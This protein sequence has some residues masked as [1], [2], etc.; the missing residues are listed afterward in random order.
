MGR[1]DPATT[2]APFPSS[3][4]PRCPAGDDHVCALRTGSVVCWGSNGSGELGNGTYNDASLPAVVTGLTD[5][6]QVASGAYHT[7]AVRSDATAVCWGGNDWGQLGNGTTAYS[8]VPVAV[9]GLTNVASISAGTAYSCALKKDASV[10]CWGRNDSGQLG[11]GSNPKQLTPQ[12]VAGLT[13]VSAISAGDNHACVIASAGA[14]Y[15]WGSNSDGQLGNSTVMESNA[16]MQV[17]G[18]TGATAIASG[19]QYSCAIVGSGVRCWGSN[20]AGRLGNSSTNDS[21]T[22]VSAFAL[23]GAATIAAGTHSCA[24]TTSGAVMCWGT[25]GWGNL[26]IGDPTI[27]SV[28][29]PPSV[30][31]LSDVAAV[32]VGGDYA[33]ALTH[34][35]HISCWGNNS[36][37]RTGRNTR[38]MATSPIPVV[39]VSNATEVVSGADH[40]C[41]AL[42]DGGITCWGDNTFGQLAVDPSL[43]ASGTPLPAVVPTLSGLAM[44]GSHSCGVAAGDAGVVCWGCDVNGQLGNGTWQTWSP[45]NMPSSFPVPG[46]ATSVVAGSDHT[47]AVVA[48]GGIYCAGDG[49]WGEIGNG[50]TAG[51][52]VP[53]LATTGVLAAEASHYDTCVTGSAGSHGVLGRERRRSSRDL[54]RRPIPPVTPAPF[55]MLDGGTPVAIAQGYEHACALLSGESVSCWGQ[56]GAGQLGN[57]TGADSPTPVAVVLSGA[58]KQ[59]VAG[60]YHS[61]A[62]LSSGTVACWG[63]GAKGQLGNGLGVN[64]LTPVGVMGLRQRRRADG[65]RRR[66][67]NARLKDSG[68]AVCWGSNPDGQLGDGTP[69]LFY[70]PGAVTGF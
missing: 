8:S 5:A 24:S 22:P 69:A 33:C 14:V 25:N 18:I 13:G 65:G 29:V 44:G 12:P 56:N 42:A 7:C 17:A 57:G 52:P 41:A 4:R 63:G 23:N 9:A 36:N 48:D 19:D 10:V 27:Q 64:S 45:Y 47:C 46:A 67:V 38:T 16:P 32:A 37:G 26:G 20:W 55:T 2:V 35:G 51:S 59:I 49:Q 53:V 6:T 21:A 15:C 70:S 3:P 39:G 28:D 30:L 1:P 43:P 34:S 54:H 68:T 60:A 11:N 31:G 40:S 50:S 66:H 62:L 58:A 61:C